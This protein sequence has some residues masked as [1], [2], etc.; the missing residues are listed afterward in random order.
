ML[1]TRVLYIRYGCWDCVRQKGKVQDYGDSVPNGYKYK[2]SFEK[3][4]GCRVISDYTMRPT[5]PDIKTMNTN[6][7]APLQ[8]TDDH[9]IALGK[10]VIAFQNLEQVITHGLAFLMQPN[11]FEEALG[12][13]SRVLNELSFAGR[14]KLLSNYV[15]T[16]PQAH[17]IPHGTQYES[18]KAEEFPMVLETLRGAISKAANLEERRNQ[19]IHSYWLT[20]ISGPSGTVWRIKSRA[21]HSKT[22]GS[23]EFLTAKAILD[24]VEEMNS[25]RNAIFEATR[26]LQIFL[27]SN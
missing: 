7:I 8:F 2:P 17:F 14:L 5:K 3:R 20:P 22:H 1:L 11:D 27:K 24:V 4:G 18:V 23:S 19:L 9:Y 25:A 12:F 26:H 21:R 13:T 15:E 6:E 16:N 10:L